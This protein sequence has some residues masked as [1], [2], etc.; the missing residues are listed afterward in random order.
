[1]GFSVEESRDALIA[2][3]GDASMATDILLSASQ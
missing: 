2:S 1:M 3:R